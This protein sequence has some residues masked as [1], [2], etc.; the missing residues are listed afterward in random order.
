MTAKNALT[1]APSKS[2]LL[3][4]CSPVRLTDVQTVNRQDSDHIP[5]LDVNKRRGERSTSRYVPELSV[6]FPAEQSKNGREQ[7]IEGEDGPDP[8]LPLVQSHDQTDVVPLAI[9]PPTVMSKLLTVTVLLCFIIP[10]A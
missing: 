8:G 10:K 6:R 4:P 5:F 2:A 3:L 7:T 9:G 1:A